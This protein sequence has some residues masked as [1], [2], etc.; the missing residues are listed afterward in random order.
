MRNVL[1]TAQSWV[2]RWKERRANLHERRAEQIGDPV[3]RLKYLRRAMEAEE[4]PPARWRGWMK[5]PELAAAALV[6]IGGGMW[7]WAGRGPQQVQARTDPAAPL[8]TAAE[9]PAKAIEP[10]AIEDLVKDKDI[11]LVEQKPGYEVYSNGLRVE[12]GAT[13][14]HERRED[15]VIDD[16]DRKVVIGAKNPA[17]I[18]FHT[19]ESHI[20][21]FE[22]GN[23]QRLQRVGRWLLDFVAA[24]R[25]YHY[26]IDRFGRVHRVVAETDVAWHAGTSAWG[27]DGKDYVGLNHSFLAVSFESETKHGDKVSESVTAAQVHAAKTLTAMLRRKYGIDARNCVTH[28]QVSLNSSSMRIGS[29]VDW[30]ANFPFAEVGLPDNYIQPIAAIYLFGYGYDDEF[31]RATGARMWKGL[32]LSEDQVRQEATQRGLT[33]TRYRSLLQQRYRAVS[34]KIAARNADATRSDSAASAVADNSRKER[35]P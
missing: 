19:T 13:I 15:V 29:H 2:A 23:N 31:V 34:A 22:A 17:G 6:L 27:R 3:A 1:G 4:R 12:T 14:Q 24:N 20:A 5:R 18:V 9:Q 7:L 21:P 28:A 8:A 26:V 32:G 16:E 30:A 33:V 11:W 10:R 35:Q 25:C